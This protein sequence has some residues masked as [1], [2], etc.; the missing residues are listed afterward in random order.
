VTTAAADS[1]VRACV[2]VIVIPPQAMAIAS[3][4]LTASRR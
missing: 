4:R 3:K 1:A 2:V